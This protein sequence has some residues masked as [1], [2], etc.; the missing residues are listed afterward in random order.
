M[1]KCAYLCVV[2]QQPL[3]FYD[4]Q[5]KEIAQKSEE[6]EQNVKRDCDDQRVDWPEYWPKNMQAEY[7]LDTAEC[8]LG[9]RPVDRLIFCAYWIRVFLITTDATFCKEDAMQ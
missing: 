9:R 4:G 2:L 5:N 3:P 7:F 6:D 1:P 8:S